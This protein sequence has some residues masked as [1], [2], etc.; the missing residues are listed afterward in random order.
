MPD[1]YERDC[2]LVAA[3]V[4]GGLARLARGFFPDI[5][6]FPASLEG[7]SYKGFMGLGSRPVYGRRHFMRNGSEAG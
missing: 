4:K 2:A 5:E 6:A 3:M 7:P 1:G